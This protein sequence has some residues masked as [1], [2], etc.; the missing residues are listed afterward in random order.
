[1]VVELV[2]ADGNRLAEQDGNRRAR[3]QVPAL[4]LASVEREGKDRLEFHPSADLRRPVVHVA[5]REEQ[6]ELGEQRPDV[7]HRVRQLGADLRGIAAGR[8]RTGDRSGSRLLRPGDR[9]ERTAREQDRCECGAT[10]VHHSP[11]LSQGVTMGNQ[12]SKLSRYDMSSSSLA[13]SPV[14]FTSPAVIASASVVSCRTIRLSVARE[15]VTP[16][17]GCSTWRPEVWLRTPLL[18]SSTAFSF[19]SGKSKFSTIRLPSAL[20]ASSRMARKSKKR[21]RSIAR[22]VSGLA[23]F[24]VGSGFTPSRSSFAPVR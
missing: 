20:G 13:R 18:I 10:D 1:L 6:V 17:S 24:G 8:C 16:A 14:T 9:G 23:V 22:T 5:V 12:N 11:P 21:S 15:S 7:G 3:D 4:L 19:T 2:E